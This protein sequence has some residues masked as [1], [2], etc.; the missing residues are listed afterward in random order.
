[1]KW[2][3]NWTEGR[4]IILLCC[5]WKWLRNHPARH[6]F[7]CPVESIERRIY[8]IRGNKGAHQEL[9]LKMAELERT[10]KERAAHI[11]GIYQMIE[12]LMALEQVP[13]GHRIGFVNGEEKNK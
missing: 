12:D 1:M 11:A 2:P 7:R 13:P 4:L 5:G 9:A 6:C 8:L 3:G 10:Q